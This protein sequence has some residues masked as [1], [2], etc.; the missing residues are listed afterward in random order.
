MKPI[1][2]GGDAG[3]PRETES[4][5]PARKGGRKKLPREERNRRIKERERRFKK[6]QLAG[7]DPRWTSRAMTTEQ[8]IAKVQ[9]VH[10]DRYGYELTE[11]R[12]SEIKVKIW[13]KIHGPFEQRPFTHMGGSGCQECAK[14]K[15][16]ASARR[17]G[18]TTEEFI[19]KA[20][21]IHGS[22]YGYEKVEYKNNETP[23]TIVCKEHGE[24]EQ[25]PR[26]HLG[27]RG[28]NACR[29]MTTN[30]VVYIYRADGFYHH[31]P[32]YKPGITSA[33]LGRSRIFEG[34]QK[35]GVTPKII[36]WARVRPGR[37][38]EIERELLALG[39][40]PQYRG[41]KGCTEMRAFS[42]ADLRQ[43]IRIVDAA[44]VGI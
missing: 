1:L 3:Q 34:A 7:E 13:C 28:C 24:F 12:G 44:S 21:E 15:V 16:K 6:S 37:A 42:F 5:L 20:I 27:G 26:S 9:A 32:V 40:D 38:T 36:R 30:D 33:H 11:Y 22:T 25:Q 14:E 18:Y 39:V 23:V 17:R 2:P 4:R 8:Y 31:G 35:A 41:F 10:G 43:A 29:N 19:G